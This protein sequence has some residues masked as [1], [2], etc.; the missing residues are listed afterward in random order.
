MARHEIGFDRFRA[1]S[2]ADRR[3]RERLSANFCTQRPGLR[4]LNETKRGLGSSNKGM[5]S[6]LVAYF[7]Q[8]APYFAG[9]EETFT[10]CRPAADLCFFSLA[11]FNEF[12]DRLLNALDGIADAAPESA[13]INWTPM[14]RICR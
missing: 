3:Q 14:N 13:S 9:G 2:V 5:C 8:I 4:A 11:Q 10:A 1:Q 12:K 6:D 7:N